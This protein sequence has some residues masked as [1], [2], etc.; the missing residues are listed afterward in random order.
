MFYRNWSLNFLPK[1]SNVATCCNVISIS[2]APTQGTLP[3]LLLHLG[4]ILNSSFPIS[5]SCQLY[6]QTVSRIWTHLTSSTGIT[7]NE[8]KIY[9]DY[10]NGL[11]TDFSASIFAA[12]CSILKI[13]K[14]GFLFKK[15]CY[16]MYHFSYSEKKHTSK[17]WPQDPS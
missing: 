10:N 8:T 3:V 4:L 2:Q 14:A 13:V 17:K 15:L 9:P 16:I 1:T 11:P 7:L 12:L 6:L 5:K